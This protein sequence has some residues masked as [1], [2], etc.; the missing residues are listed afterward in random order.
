MHQIQDLQYQASHQQSVIVRL[1]IRDNT[2]PQLN[3]P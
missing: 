1:N 2:I 3:F